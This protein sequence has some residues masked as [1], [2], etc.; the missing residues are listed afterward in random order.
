MLPVFNDSFHLEYKLC[1]QCDR[2]RLWRGPRWGRQ[3]QLQ[4]KQQKRKRSACLLHLKSTVKYWCLLWFMIAG[5]SSLLKSLLI[6]LSI[7]TWLTITYLPRESNS[8]WNKTRK[9]GS[10]SSYLMYKIHNNLD[11]LQ[12]IPYRYGTDKPTPSWI[13]L[14]S[15]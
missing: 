4:V 1:I 13:L 6:M 10:S 11:W 12:K 9:T 3:C 8:V 5:L 14:L 15:L 7:I 2:D